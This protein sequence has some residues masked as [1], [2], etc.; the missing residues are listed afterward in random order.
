MTN[1]SSQLHLGSVLATSFIRDISGSRCYVTSL[2]PF[3]PHLT[4][5]FNVDLECCKKEGLSTGFREDTLRTMK[6]LQVFR[7][8]P[9]IEGLSLR[10]KVPPQEQPPTKAHGHR[11]RSA[12]PPS[13]SSG[14]GPST[15]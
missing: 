3:I 13:S 10:P 1:P 9:Y 15:S 2:G 6:L 12:T 7:L 14:I 8:F 11:R 4:R 5:H